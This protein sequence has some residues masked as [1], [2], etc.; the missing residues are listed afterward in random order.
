M[1]FRL[2]LYQELLLQQQFEL[3]LLKKLPSSA[4]RLYSP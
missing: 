4:L 2:H 1:L 3:D